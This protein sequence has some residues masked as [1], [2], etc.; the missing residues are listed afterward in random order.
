MEQ[1]ARRVF[2]TRLSERMIPF[3]LTISNVPGPHIRRTSTAPSSWPAARTRRSP[4]AWPSHQSYNGHLD[5]GIVASAAGRGKLAGTLGELWETVLETP[6]GGGPC[7]DL[8]GTV[9]PFTVIG[10]ATLDCTVK[11]GTRSFIVA[12]SAE[13]SDVESPPFFG[14][15]EN[16]Q[17]ACARSYDE[18]FAGTTVTLDGNTVALTEVETAQLV[19]HLPDGNLLTGVAGPATSS[20]H[21]WVALVHPLTPGTHTIEIVGPAGILSTRQRSS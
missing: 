17:R 6:G 15:D 12:A 9:A 8:G 2:S 1:A 20:A 18:Q 5:R 3:N 19:L 7:Y 11:P 10:A 21:G 13:C 4:P 14:A 16:D